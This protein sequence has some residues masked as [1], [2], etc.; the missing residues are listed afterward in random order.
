MVQ[1][2]YLFG[3]V[4][5]FLLI[6]NS[7]YSQRICDLLSSSKMYQVSGSLDFKISNEIIQNDTLNS[8]IVVFSDSSGQ[9]LSF[10]DRS[11]NVYIV[12]YKYFEGGEYGSLTIYSVEG[13]DLAYWEFTNHMNLSHFVKYHY[14]QKKWRD[15]RFGCPKGEGCNWKHYPKK[16]FDNLTF[17]SD[18]AQFGKMVKTIIR[19][20]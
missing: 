10:Y 20:R 8:K 14:S 16:Y 12:P 18:V 5:I 7:T 4:L 1:N 19:N 3:L 11:N 9:L 6:E 15:V 17:E 2:K 13:E